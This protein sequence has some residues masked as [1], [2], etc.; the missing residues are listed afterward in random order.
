MLQYRSIQRRNK[1]KLLLV[2]DDDN[3]RNNMEYFLNE[4]NLGC[5]IESC[6]FDNVNDTE[7]N[8][9]QQ[10][11]SLNVTDY[12]LIDLFLGG[13][14]E[15]R[16]PYRDLK[17]VKM[18]L[19][20]GIP[21]NHIIFYSNGNE[22]EPN[23]LFKIVSGCKY[24]PITAAALDRTHEKDYCKYVNRRNSIADKIRKFLSD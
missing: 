9:Q 18:V 7:K 15:S 20:L 13:Q 21:K 2:D 14:S 17:S 22:R 11:A 3:V 23:A 8:I 1:M 5:E 4:L 12:L 10:M 16:T 6:L 24:I 19:N